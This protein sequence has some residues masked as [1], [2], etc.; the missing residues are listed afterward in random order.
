MEG[1]YR[2]TKGNF[3]VSL[4]VHLTLKF[5]ASYSFRL[6]NASE[7]GIFQLG[8]KFPN[9]FPMSPPVVSFASDFWHPNGMM[10][11]LIL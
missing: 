1:V 5:M 4:Y 8:M 9:D 3:L 11:M 10:I 2:G 7:G 6:F